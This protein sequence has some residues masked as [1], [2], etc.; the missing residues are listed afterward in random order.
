M[1]LEGKAVK[2]MNSIHKAITSLGVTAL[3]GGL[4]PAVSIRFG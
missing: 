4:V 3:L 1:N 2:A